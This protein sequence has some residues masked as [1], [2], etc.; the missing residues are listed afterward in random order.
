VGDSPS[1]GGFPMVAQF[2]IVGVVLAGWQWQALAV[3]RESGHGSGGHAAA[4]SGWQ[5]YNACMVALLGWEGGGGCAAVLVRW[6]QG[7]S[8]REG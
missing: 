1:V 3:G 2:S 6:R 5:R 8:G 4:L 7:L